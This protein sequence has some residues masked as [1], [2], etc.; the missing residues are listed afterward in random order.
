[1]VDSVH[2]TKEGLVVGGNSKGEVMLW[3]LDL[4]AFKKQLSNKV[5]IFLGSWKKHQKTVH[6]C[7]FSPD[8]RYL[9]TGSVDG[10]AKIW[11]IQNK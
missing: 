7:E 5:A 4:V 2:V 11:N 1:M 9:F 10:T 3:Q 6:F 8:G